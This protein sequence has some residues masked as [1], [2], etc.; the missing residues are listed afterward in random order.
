M[1]DTHIQ[2]F[3]YIWGDIMTHYDYD[4]N[5]GFTPDDQLQGVYF[6]KYWSLS[7]EE[8]LLD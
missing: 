7:M 6:P 4:K 2:A 5:V 8:Y 1:K 3:Q